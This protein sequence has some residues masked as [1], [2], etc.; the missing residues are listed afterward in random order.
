MKKGNDG[1][2][3]RS[4]ADVNG[5]YRWRKVAAA[6]AS[7]TKTVKPASRTKRDAPRGAVAG[8][9]ALSRKALLA[10]RKQAEATLVERIEARGLGK[11]RDRILAAAW[12]CVRASYRVPGRGRIPTGTSRVGGLPDVPE[13]FVWPTATRAGAKRAKGAKKR[14]EAPPRFPLSFIGQINCADVAPF[15]LTGV[16]PTSGL[17]SYFLDLGSWMGQRD[18]V[19]VFY[20]PAG[21]PLAQ[22]AAPPDLR[23]EDVYG[24]VL[25]TKFRSLLSL[26]REPDE[27]AS[28]L[29]KGLSKA[30][31]ELVQLY[32]DDV[33]HLIDDP[34][35][36]AP[37]QLLGYPSYVHGGATSKAQTLLLSF[38]PP[39]N[40][41]SRGDKLHDSWPDGDFGDTGL[42]YCQ[43]DEADLR[44]LRLDKAWGCTQSS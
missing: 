24:V 9:A 14:G 40:Y 39:S 1:N 36:D 31:P 8:R 19:A 13:G 15:E 6:A 28:A 44:A 27:A 22:A 17:L 34:Q 4:V 20:T 11:V 42:F 3:Y 7:K 23:K 21:T 16:L 25:L 37:V 43:I 29:F 2:R 30:G 41:G 10:A 26:P 38:S 33:Y 5:V 12:P 18:G 32:T 35:G